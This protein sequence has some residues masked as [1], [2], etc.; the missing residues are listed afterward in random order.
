[1]GKKKR[2]DSTMNSI[3]H[4]LPHGSELN[5]FK[6]TFP[7]LQPY[8]DNLDE[9]MT[10]SL[11]KELESH[12]TIAFITIGNV[13]AKIGIIISVKDDNVT[14]KDN[15]VQLNNVTCSL[16]IGIVQNDMKLFSH[17]CDKEASTDK[18]KKL[19]PGCHYF[20]RCPTTKQFCS[21]SIGMYLQIDGRPMGLSTGH[22]F[23]NGTDKIEHLRVDLGSLHFSKFERRVRNEELIDAGVIRGMAYSVADCSL[24]QMKDLECVNEF[25]CNTVTEGVVF[26]V[27][28]TEIADSF[29]LKNEFNYFIITRERNE[30]CELVSY[31]RV[32]VWNGTIDGE[33]EYTREFAL[34]YKKHH[35]HY[36]VAEGESMLTNVQG[37]C[38]NVVFHFNEKGD[39]VV[40]GMFIGK[41]LFAGI[42]I[43]STMSWVK[44]NLE[45]PLVL[46]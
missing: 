44:K 9:F 23:R 4:I 13:D 45:S 33:T 37:D 39:A 46:I 15:V 21:A 7:T 26:P 19:R 36:K 31:G 5:C 11:L 16:P 40:D 42:A 25:T 22:S 28:F 29:D 43:F 20:T 12:F 8:F 2:G 35:D 6:E 24:I 17:L 3:I 41:D 14:I 18:D 27:K 38:G 34:K 30:L 10:C 32:H 1:M